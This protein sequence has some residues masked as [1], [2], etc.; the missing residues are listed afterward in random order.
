LNPN[1][2]VTIAKNVM[3]R[4][5]APVKTVMLMMETAAIDPIGNDAVSA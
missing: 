4:P 5:R 3:H 1:Q 2:G